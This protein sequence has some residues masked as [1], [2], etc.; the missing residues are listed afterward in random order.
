MRRLGITAKIWLSIGVF[1]L[2]AL[3]AL[4]VGQVQGL[5]SEQRLAA[6]NDAIAAT[7][8]LVSLLIVVPPD[9]I[10]AY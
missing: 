5:V 7:A 10:A 1:V 2:G 8:A 9:S 6:T 4:G 3:A